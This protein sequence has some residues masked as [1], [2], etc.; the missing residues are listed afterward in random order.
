MKERWTKTQAKQ[1]KRSFY[2]SLVANPWKRNG[3]ENLQK[4]QEFL[5]EMYKWILLYV[6]L[7]GLYHGRN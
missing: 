7:G 1:Q 3:P 2:R 4:L 5:G 6:S